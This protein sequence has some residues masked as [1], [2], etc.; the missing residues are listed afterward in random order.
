V[1]PALI[2]GLCKGEVMPTFES[3]KAGYTAMWNTVVVTRTDAAS[4]AAR[5]IIAM[6][7]IYEEAEK[8]TGAPWYFIGALHMR[9]CNNNMR[10]CLTNGEMIVGTNKKT[11]LETKGRGPFPTW[12]DSAKDCAELED[13]DKVTDWSIERCLYEGEKFNGW[14]YLPKGVNSPYVW[15]GTNHYTKGKYVSD[16]RYSASHVDTQ[17]GIGCVMKA[18][19]EIAYANKVP[20]S[21]SSGVASFGAYAGIGGGGAVGIAQQFMG[22]ATDW[23][24]IAVVM[25]VMVGAG[26]LF[27][28]NKRQKLREYREG[29]L[30]PSGEKGGFFNV[31]TIE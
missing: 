15:A 29:R 26:A 10:G 18:V 7:P 23:R 4:V 11:R 14:G 20:G 28:W 9:E 19:I 27:L 17:L 24:T 1:V 8:A 30:I 16:G 2:N 5:K 21:R 3:M 12:L 6:R 13:W 22:F 25:A 31:E